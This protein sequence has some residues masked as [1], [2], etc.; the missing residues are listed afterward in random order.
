MT[1]QEAVETCLKKK[2]ADFEG[3]AT[4][5]EYWW[6]ALFIFIVG[7][8]LTILAKPVALLFYVGTLVPSVAVG[9]RRLH[10]TNRSGWWLL[11]G[12]VP[13]IGW[14]LLL[15]FMT[16]PGRTVPTPT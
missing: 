12:L 8:L 16:Q 2:Y 9:I 6:F 10:D 1:F 11:V 14:L 5:S 13:F 15:I 3:D 7:T 4:R